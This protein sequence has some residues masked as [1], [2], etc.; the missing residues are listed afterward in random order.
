M[1]ASS[2]SNNAI[3]NWID[4]EISSN[5]VVIFSKTYCPYCHRAKSAFQAVGLDKYTVH[6]LDKRDDGDI[7]LDVLKNM[8]GA[9]TV[10]I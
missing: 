1:G 10:R 4:Q 7:I 3:K 6:E 8:T 2:S 5:L 9:R